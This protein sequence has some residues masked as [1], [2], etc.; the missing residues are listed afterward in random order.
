MYFFFL[1]ISFKIDTGHFALEVEK[2]N[3][4]PTFK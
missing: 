1:T 2:G 4:E 3:N